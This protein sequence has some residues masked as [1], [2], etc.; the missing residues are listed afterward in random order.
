MT[1]DRPPQTREFHVTSHLTVND[2]IGAALRR[3]TPPQYT[4]GCDVSADLST[5]VGGRVS[6]LV[7][8]GRP[9]AESADV[10]HAN[11]TSEMGVRKK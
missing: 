7:I 6:C 5:L 2:G 4:A 9:S 11:V 3:I 8:P 10:N 1:S